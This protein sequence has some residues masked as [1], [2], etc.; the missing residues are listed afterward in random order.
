MWASIS[1]LACGFLEAAAV[2]VSAADRKLHKGALVTLNALMARSRFFFSSFSL[3]LLL[4]AEQVVASE[5]GLLALLVEE[6][7]Y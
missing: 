2:L 7:T 4:G 1:Y 3:N 6:C 5:L